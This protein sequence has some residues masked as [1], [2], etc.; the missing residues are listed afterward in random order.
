[1]QSTSVCGGNDTTDL[2]ERHAALIAQGEKLRIRD[3]AERLGVAEGRLV[4]EALG[5]TAVPLDIRPRE[6][7]HRLPALGRVMA[8][9]RNDACVHER[10]GR[11]EDVQVGPGP[12]GLVLG[13]DIDLRLFLS[14]WRHVF[15][16]DDAGRESLQCF[17]G[18]GQAL[19]KIYRTDETDGQAW[20]DLVDSLANPNLP[21]RF[22]ALEAARDAAARIPDGFRDGVDDEGQRAVLREAWLALKDTHD[23][24]PMM[25]RLKLTRR[26]ALTG[27]GSDLAQSVPATV[28][29]SVLTAASEQALPIM[30]FVGNPGIIQI[31][32]GPV[33]R[34][35]RTGR[36]LNV[37]D[38]TFN[39][40]L[41]T[42][43]IAQCF[44][45]QKPSVDGWITSIEALA[46]DGSL[47]VQCFGERKPG[48]PELADWRALLVRHCESPLHA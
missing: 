27:V 39:L 16:V 32:S 9:T 21:I 30:C 17:D 4:A 20:R 2:A 11:F 41:D 31:H 45:V 7:F 33:R 44:I 3:R 35:V 46:A 13:P 43:A 34:L 19:H 22:D 42:T 48:R 23:F 47:I 40:H 15:A 25:H 5:V 28:I 12:V 1:M 37:L 24:F 26:G 10:H 8:L 38:P 36:W 6:L 18:A 29:E 14:G